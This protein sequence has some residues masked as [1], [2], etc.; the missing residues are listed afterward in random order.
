MIIIVG[1][2]QQEAEEDEHWDHILSLLCCLSFVK[3]DSSQI[4]VGR[5][6]QTWQNTPTYTERETLASFKS[7]DQIMSTAGISL[8]RICRWTTYRETVPLNV[9]SS[10]AKN[11]SCITKGVNRGISQNSVV[12]NK[13]PAAF[14]FL[15]S[16]ILSVDHLHTY[17]EGYTQKYISRN[18]IDTGTQLQTERHLMYLLNA[19]RN[20][21]GNV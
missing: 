1:H 17:I 21:D 8:H 5:Q 6:N 2:P 13:R 20:F 4:V 18:I 10:G 7:K 14:A 9:F 11:N 3:R 12:V 19:L 15:F 16:R